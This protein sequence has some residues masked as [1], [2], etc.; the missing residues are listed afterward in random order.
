[1]RWER[2]LESVAS[3]ARRAHALDAALSR[4]S[5]LTAV[6]DALGG[7]PEA[8]LWAAV[9]ASFEREITATSKATSS[10]LFNTTVNDFPKMMRMMHQLVGGGD[11]HVA[12]SDVALAAFAP[13]ENQFLGRVLTRMFEPIN[14]YFAAGAAG[15]SGGAAAQGRIATVAEA[16]QVVLL[17][18]KCVFEKGLW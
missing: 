18:N 6:S 11:A 15:V 12:A 4:L 16:Q 14:S 8:R 2:C 10:F 13:L 17:L 9:S 1:M 5:L 7:S 3:Q